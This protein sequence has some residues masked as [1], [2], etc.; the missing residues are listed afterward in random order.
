MER[1]KCGAASPTNA[2]SP[3]CATAAPVAR[4]NTPTSA[5]RSCGS[6]RPR[7]S[8]VA[9][10][11]ARPSSTGL[12][13]QAS[14]M[15][16]NQVSAITAQADHPTYPVLPNMKACMFCSRSGRASMIRSFTE[17]STTPT[18]TPASSSRSVC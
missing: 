10:P 8:A 14:P 11:S 15:Q 18:I 17:P 1:T 7:L 12:N 2:M 9:S 13:T 5:A 16:N 3:V 6:G 4:A